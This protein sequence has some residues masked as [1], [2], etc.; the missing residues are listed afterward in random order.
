MCSAG[1]TWLRCL[2]LRSTYYA[3]FYIAIYPV[4]PHPFDFVGNGVDRL[5]PFGLSSIY[6]LR[7]FFL[8]VFF[9]FFWN[10]LMATC[11]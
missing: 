10:H 8:V 5:P 6:I 3:F 2:S 9:T 11:T 1:G 7:V 4:L